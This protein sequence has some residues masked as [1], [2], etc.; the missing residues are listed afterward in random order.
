MLGFLSLVAWRG[1]ASGA[2]V[3][4]WS[5]VGVAQAIFSA[6]IR[7]AWTSDPDRASPSRWRNLMAL[8]AA[9]RGAVDTVWL[10]LLAPWD[11]PAAMTAVLIV[12]VTFWI[13][14]AV[15]FASHGMVAAIYLLSAAMALASVLAHHREYPVLAIVAGPVLAGVGAFHLGMRRRARAQIRTLGELELKTAEQHAVFDTIA[16][17]VLTIEDDR[18]SSCNAR[19]ID[20]VGRPRDVVI[21]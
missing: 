17:A 3:V 1:N 6:G 5:A 12:F 21:G 20:V 19:F 10:W 4:A 11:D 8:S 16:D 15:L 9:T 13:G 18:V 2:A 7:V 14:G